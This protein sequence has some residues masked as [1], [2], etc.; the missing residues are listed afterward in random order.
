MD[1]GEP[2]LVE[3]GSLVG[4]GVGE[5]TKLGSRRTLVCR[6]GTGLP[7]MD[8]NLRDYRRNFK[9]IIQLK[10][11]ISYLQLSNYR[12]S[13]VVFFILLKKVFSSDVCESDSPYFEMDPN[14]LTQN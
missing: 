1:C 11:C 5:G 3:D 6:E 7:T 12:R 9:V 2:G 4:L 8:E 13:K 10:N 14:K